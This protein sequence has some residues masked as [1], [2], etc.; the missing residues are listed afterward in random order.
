MLTTSWR[1]KRNILVIALV[2]ILVCA[3]ISFVYPSPPNTKDIVW[4]TMWS[5]NYINIH[6][7]YDGNGKAWN[8]QTLWAYGMWVFNIYDWSYLF[9]WYGL[10]WDKLSPL[11]KVPTGKIDMYFYNDPSDWALAWGGN[12]EIKCNLNGMGLLDISTHKWATQVLQ[13]GNTV[14]HEASHNIY[15]SY[16]GSKWNI[17]DN[18]WLTEALAYNTGS[19]LWAWGKGDYD[20]GGWAPKYSKADVGAAYRARASD[21]AGYGGLLTWSNAGYRYLNNA[22]PGSNSWWTFHAAGYNLFNGWSTAG[23][24]YGT[25]ALLLQRIVSGTSLSNS[26]KAMTGFTMSVNNNSKTDNTDY[27][28]YFYQYW[29]V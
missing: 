26:W 21:A 2:A 9:G 4:N 6:F 12:M 16:L 15:Y 22:D 7:Q 27:Y 8:N 11:T 20:A 28:Y 17:G 25:P 1:G 29:W 19:C 10:G 14:S 23:N 3:T 24:T 18:G 5:S 13:Y